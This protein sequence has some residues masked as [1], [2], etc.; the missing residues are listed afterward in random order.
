[1]KYKSMLILGALFV[2]GCK[3]RMAQMSGTDAGVAE[4]QSRKLHHFC[5][6]KGLRLSRKDISGAK[7]DLRFLFKFADHQNSHGLDRTRASQYIEEDKLA[8]ATTSDL[9]CVS[10]LDIIDVVS[11]LLEE[12]T[13]AAYTVE[14]LESKMLGKDD[15]TEVPSVIK[16]F[17]LMIN[18]LAE[19]IRSLIHS[20]ILVYDRRVQDSMIAIE[21]KKDGILYV[22]NELGNGD[23]NEMVFD[24][25]K[26]IDNQIEK[27]LAKLAAG[28]GSSDSDARS[29]RRKE[30]E[31]LIRKPLLKALRMASSGWQQFGRSV[32]F[33][34]SAG[35]SSQKSKDE[36]KF[37]CD[38]QF[39]F[40]DPNSGEVT[41]FLR[42]SSKPMK[43]LS[44]VIS[45]SV[46]PPS[47]PG[48]LVLMLGY[49]CTRRT[50]D[51]RWLD[52][53]GTNLCRP[54]P[55][56]MKLT[57]K[58]GKD[59]ERDMAFEDVTINFKNVGLAMVAQ[60]NLALLRNNKL[61][62]IDRAFKDRSAKS[63][64]SRLGDYVYTNFPKG[65][66][67]DRQTQDFTLSCVMPDNPFKFAKRPKNAFL[68]QDGLFAV[69]QK[70]K[71]DEAPITPANPSLSMPDEN[72]YGDFSC[73]FFKANNI[74]NKAVLC[75]C[76]GAANFMGMHYFREYEPRK[77]PK[78]YDSIRSIW[79]KIRSIGKKP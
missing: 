64:D 34:V 1:M 29:E 8:Q 2:V 45:G 48:S 28:E 12:N 55:A 7:S 3:P 57:Y 22:K 56:G 32:S 42:I 31:Q 18:G 51:Y 61:Q 9:N 5:L 44:K 75:G 19:T 62:D 65:W 26:A 30:F 35:C 36:L 24:L 39:S 46:P 37:V 21:W 49:D 43:S 15:N 60:H 4:A 76:A 79:K 20:T 78:I 72:L 59:S 69:N 74:E 53:G 27:Q 58:F 17:T 14:W 73:L 71:M 23:K 11:P 52:M 13:L 10:S 33:G 63:L 25:G 66:N 54:G 40:N 68:D 16:A 6:E 47:A 38:A 67:S 77:N 41:D 50:H 70:W